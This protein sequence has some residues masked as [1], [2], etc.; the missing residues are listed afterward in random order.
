MGACHCYDT[1][2]EDV[3]V[4]LKAYDFL[5][6]KHGWV[7]WLEGP[8]KCVLYWTYIKPGEFLWKSPS[9]SL[10]AEEVEIACSQRNVCEPSSPVLLAENINIWMWQFF[11]LIYQTWKSAFTCQIKDNYQFLLFSTLAIASQKPGKE[12]AFDPVWILILALKRVIEYKSDT[13]FC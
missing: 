3:N 10:L 9:R 4:S 12:L 5:F 1:D 13:L 6:V 11:I 7:N 2:F 8:W